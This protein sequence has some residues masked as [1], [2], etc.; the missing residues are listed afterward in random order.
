[1]FETVQAIVDDFGFSP[2]RAALIAHMETATAYEVG[3]AEQFSKYANM[4]GII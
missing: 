3:K 2:Y 4:G 1:M